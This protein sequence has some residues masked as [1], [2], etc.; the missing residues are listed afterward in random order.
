[1]YSLKIRSITAGMPSQALAPS[2][3]DALGSLFNA[4]NDLFSAHDIPIQTRR[5]VLDP[6]HPGQNVNYPTLRSILDSIAARIEHIGV[7]W[8]CLP[9]SLQEGWGQDDIRQHCVELIR[10][11][12]FLFLHA[13]MHGNHGVNLD[14]LT[15][16][17]KTILDISTLSESGYDNFRFGV[18]ANIRPNTPFFPF[19]WHDGAK[20]F[21]LAVEILGPLLGHFTR[22]DTASM[23]PEQLRENLTAFLTDIC[24]IVDTIGLELQ[25]HMKD[26]FEYK[27]MDISLAPFPDGLHSV[28]RLMESVGPY[29]FGGMGTVSATAFFTRLIKDA[30]RLSGARS[31]GFNGVMYSPLEDSDLARTLSFSNMQVEHFLLYSTMC[32]CGVD[33]VP[34]EGNANRVSLATLI[35]DVFTISTRLSKPLG[36]RVLP[37]PMGRVNEQTQ[38]NHDFLVNTRILG[39]EGGGLLCGGGSNNFK[40]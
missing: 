3:W 34:I 31:V 19:S 30:I 6:I 36:V 8:V 4:A 24:R 27:G 20:G 38:F 10:A 29:T 28:S 21:S 37:I 33:M 13:M 23:P 22:I 40:I 32:G 11:Y 18:G 12:P 17:A 35:Q 39:L 2:D 25:G 7:R 5:M 9:L 1:M 15:Q 16:L 14:R 26:A